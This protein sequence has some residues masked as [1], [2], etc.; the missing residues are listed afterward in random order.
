MDL[1][2]PTLVRAAAKLTAIGLMSLASIVIRS[3]PEGRSSSPTWAARLRRD[4]PPTGVEV[5][6]LGVVA[7][8]DP[9]LSTAAGLLEGGR[10]GAGGRE[11]GRL[12]PVLTFHG[13]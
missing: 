4:L 2:I 9:G 12:D 7:G 11:E 5:P 6:D 13:S 10:S 3:G 8:K 1:T